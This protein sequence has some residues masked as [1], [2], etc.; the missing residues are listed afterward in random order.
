MRRKLYRGLATRLLTGC[1]D[2]YTMLHDTLEGRISWSQEEGVTLV[3]D[4]KTVTVENLATILATH[5]GWGFRLTI[6]DA[7]Q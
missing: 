2:A 5:E 6:L 1:P 4:S 3:V 7:L